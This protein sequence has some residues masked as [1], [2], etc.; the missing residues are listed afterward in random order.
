MEKLSNTINGCMS[1]FSKELPDL[2]S[3]VALVILLMLIH[4]VMSN[5]N[6]SGKRKMNF[7]LSI[8]TK[9]NTCFVII[10]QT[11]FLKFKRMISTTLS[12]YLDLNKRPCSSNSLLMKSWNVHPESSGLFYQMRNKHSVYMQTLL[13]YCYREIQS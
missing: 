11:A 9:W 5:W 7:L 1:C 2:A 8:R 6:K 10:C 13:E 12:G 4:S 3:P